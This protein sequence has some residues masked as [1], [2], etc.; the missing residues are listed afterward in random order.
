MHVV[1]GRDLVQGLGRRS[2]RLSAENFF[3][4]P[5]QNVKIGGTAGTHYLREFQYLTRGFRVDIVDF[6]NFN[7]QPASCLL[8]HLFP[9][10]VIFNVI[11]LTN[12]S[13][14]FII[15]NKGLTCL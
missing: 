11:R 5:L 6:V 8:Q 13:R 12:D 10:I 1:I 4:H 7:I 15:T 14:H 2:R 9:D 3:C